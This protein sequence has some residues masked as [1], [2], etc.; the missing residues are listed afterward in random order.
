MPADVN[1]LSVVGLA[2]FNPAHR[3]AVERLTGV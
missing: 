3:P 2:T 1:D